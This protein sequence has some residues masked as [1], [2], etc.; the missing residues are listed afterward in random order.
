MERRSES[1]TRLQAELDELE[2]RLRRLGAGATVDEVVEQAEQVDPDAIETRIDRLAEE[3]DALEQ[4][5]SELDRAIG[6]ES[7]VLKG[8]DGS[9]S[10]A[11]LAEQRQHI[12]GRAQKDIEQYVRLRL[13]AAVLARTIEVYREKHQGPILARTNDLFS[14]LTLGSFEGVRAEYTDQGEPVLM[15]VR[16]GSGELVGV[17]GMSDG[18]T[19]QLY[20]ALRLA[21]LESYLENNEPMPFIAD[22]ILIRFDDARAEATLRIL[23]ELAG[24]T[25]VIF[26][27]HHQHLVDLATETLSSD[28]CTYSLNGEQNA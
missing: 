7:T 21:S 28:V 24:K 1:K 26:F 4:E 11:E 15:G 19:D 6:S 9:A 17:G 5:R 23:A 14:Q 2:S 8:M 20:L 12:L 13:A 22:D 3:I 18:T 27:T 16:P 10:A 25:Q